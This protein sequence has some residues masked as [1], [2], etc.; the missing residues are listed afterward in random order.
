MRM[1]LFFGRK[2]RYPGLSYWENF[3]GGHL[4]IGKR[5]TIFGE[6]AMHWAIEIR[7]KKYGVIVFTL[8]IRTFGKYY[9]CHIYCSPNGTPWASTY[10]KSLWKENNRSEE[11]RAKIRKLNFG[12]NFNTD[13]H[14]KKLRALNEKF[15]WFKISEYDIMKWAV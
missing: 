3:F 15:D 9:G 12:H 13:T 14:S 7:T 10:Y 8:P 5:I 2:A 6:N 11:L 1:F 4:N